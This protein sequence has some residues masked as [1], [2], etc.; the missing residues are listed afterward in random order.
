M[1]LCGCGC[2]CGKVTSDRQMDREKDM[3]NPIDENLNET[4]IQAILK[5]IVPDQ[6][7]QAGTSPMLMVVRREQVLPDSMKL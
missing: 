5:Q 1:Q 3:G 4:S 7:M 6:R 2:V